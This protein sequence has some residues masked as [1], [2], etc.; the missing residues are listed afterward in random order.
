MAARGA[1]VTPWIFQDFAT[2]HSWNPDVASRVAIMRQLASHMHDYYGDTPRGHRNAD[3]SLA[4][5]LGFFCHYRQAEEEG[6][7][8]GNLPPLEALLRCT[9]VSIHARMVEGLAVARS[10]SEALRNLML[11][12]RWEANSIAA[13]AQT[14]TK[15]SYLSKHYSRG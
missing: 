6:D 14:S 4:W 9:D 2:R 11:M 5:H 1:L 10:D 8:E 13:A 12:A 3:A 7:N 15:N